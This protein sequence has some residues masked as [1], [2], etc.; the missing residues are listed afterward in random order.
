MIRLT[1]ASYG[2]LALALVPVAACGTL[3]SAMA[4]AAPLSRETPAAGEV[5]DTILLDV[6]RQSELIVR[7]K[8]REAFLR[9][10]D[11]ALLVTVETRNK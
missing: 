3:Q 9:A 11:G 7:R 6:I 1:I 2:A 4:P 10:P 8:V 5:S